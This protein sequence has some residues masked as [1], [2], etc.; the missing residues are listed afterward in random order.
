[1]R[2]VM[3]GVGL[4]VLVPALMGPVVMGQAG[5]SAG[6]ETHQFASDALNLRLR[7][8]AQMETRDLGEAT[9]HGVLSM[10]GLSEAPAAAEVWRPACGRFCCCARRSR[11]RV[12]LRRRSR[13]RMG[14][15]RRCG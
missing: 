10:P 11:R 1:M 7:Y 6:N 12:P 14:A 13:R 9:V 4:M 3:A 8:P 5:K 2:S 15:G